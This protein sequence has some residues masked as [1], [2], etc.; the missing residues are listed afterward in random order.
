MIIRAAGVLSTVL[1]L[2]GLVAVPA[3]AVTVDTFGDYSQMFTRSAGQIRDPAGNPSSQ[4][5]WEPQSASESYIRWANPATWAT[6]PGAVKEH[7]AHV[8][9]WVVLD[10]WEDNGTYY[11]QRV[12]AEFVGDASCWRLQPLAGDGR[13][14]Y[15]KW[16]VP[17][18]A[19]C[20]LAFGTVTEASS[21]ITFTFVHQQVWSPPAACSSRFLGAAT[22]I[23]QREAWSDDNGGPLALRQERVNQLARG[24]GM[25]FTVRQTVPT[26]W[27][28]DEYAVWTY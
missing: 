22:C 11:T 6:D 5:A 9:D 3:A 10:G 1:I 18:A 15:S 13:Q 4:W 25:S 2:I 14:H 16:T 23:S 20:L 7:F 19:Y 28:G 17:A 12:T 8:G 27:S 24:K 26:V 21:G